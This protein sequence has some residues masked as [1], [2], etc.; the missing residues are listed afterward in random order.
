MRLVRQAAGHAHAAREPG[1]EASDA[2]SVHGAG[3]RTHV[4]ETR[5][6]QRRQVH[7]ARRL[8]RGC[9]PGGGFKLANG[10]VVPPDGTGGIILPNGARCA[11][12]GNRG[13]LCP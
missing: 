10:V 9:R 2:V 1:V 7:P 3:I 12:D 11:S 6:L 4:H 8:E 5:D 13:Y